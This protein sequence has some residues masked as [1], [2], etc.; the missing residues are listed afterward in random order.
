MPPR[1]FPE[2]DYP[3]DRRNGSTALEGKHLMSTG[4]LV[5]LLIFAVPICGIIFSSL[6]KIARYRA[7]AAGAPENAELSARVLTLEGEMDSIRQH[8]AETQER[9]DF[10]ERLLA[11]NDPARLPEQRAGS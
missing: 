2:I 4:Q 9:L 7:K 8:L 5:L 1:P 3:V 10:A 11:R 6:E